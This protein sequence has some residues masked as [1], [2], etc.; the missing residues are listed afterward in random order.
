M[1]LQDACRDEHQQAACCV[2][3]AATPAL[4]AGQQACANTASVMQKTDQ[5]NTAAA[6]NGIRY[7]FMQGPVCDKCG[8]KGHLKPACR[9]YFC[10]SC[11]LHGHRPGKCRLACS[12]CGR[13]HAQSGPCLEVQCSLCKLFGH[14]V[15][16]CPR[17]QCAICKRYGHMHK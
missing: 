14:K 6:A 13:L 4:A 16:E 1:G 2:G 10:Y 17:V 9:E 15:S 3:S 7:M 5:P 8:C 12:R 11:Q